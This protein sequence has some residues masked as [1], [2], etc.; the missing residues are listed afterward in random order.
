MSYQFVKFFSMGLV[1]NG[2]FHM[3][4]P[5]KKAG[6]FMKDNPYYQRPAKTLILLHGFNG[7]M[8][9]WQQ[10]TPVAEWSMKYNMAIV[11][12]T[13]GVSFWLDREAT[14]HKY[15]TFVGVDL[16]NYLRETYGLAMNREDTYIGG[17]SMGGF[18]AMH[19]ALM[20]PETFCAAMGLSSAAIAKQLPEMKKNFQPNRMANLEF[21]MEQFGDL[22]KAPE[23]DINAEW[24]YKQNVEKGIQNPRI[25]MACGT[26]DFGIENNRNLAQ[27]FKDQGAD[28]EYYEAPGIH[29]W[30]FWI[31]AAEK[32]IQF[33]LEK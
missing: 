5:P 17:N 29:N 9:D 1:R 15:A 14:G 10:H 25:F 19:A 2:E 4:L 33:L 28:I 24:Q 31:P 8:D 3:Y 32:G 23:S 21:Y 7:D 22:D 12:P 20:F 11:M 26:E 16:I 27:F 30:S 6:F 18:G 13:G